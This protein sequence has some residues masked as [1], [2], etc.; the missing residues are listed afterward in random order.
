MALTILYTAT[1]SE[2]F[3]SITITDAGTLWGQGGEINVGDVTGISLSL[4]GTDKDT[5]LKI[6]TFTSGERATFLAGNGVTLLFSDSRLWGTTYQ[7][8][9]FI[10]TQL[11]VTG[12]AT[13]S[14]QVCYSSW[15]YLKK[16][17]CMHITDVAI[18]LQTF[19]D[20][21]KSITGDLAAFTSLE[22]LDS[23]I[24]AARE[25]KWRKNYDFLQ[26]NYNL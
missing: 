15:F 23:V 14:T 21:N 9:N 19:Y 17:I 16:I 4:F 22:Y 3:K 10:T 7:P 13:V 12:G 2:D 1:R 20:A 11:D 25:N 6:V 8:D 26:W 24:S 18:P 5:P